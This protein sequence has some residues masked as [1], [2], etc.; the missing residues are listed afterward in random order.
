MLIIFITFTLSLEH[1]AKLIA[2]AAAQEGLRRV[3]I[4][5]SSQGNVALSRRISDAFEKEWL[6]L[7][8]SVGM[9]LTASGE[10][11]DATKLKTSFDKAIEAM[12]KSADKLDKT[13]DKAADKATD[14]SYDK[15]SAAIEFVFIA[16]DMNAARGI[17]PYLPQGL[18]VYATSHSLDPRAGALENLDLDSVRYLEMPWFAERDHIAV[19]SYPRPPEATSADYERL[20][21]LGIDAWRI[22]MALLQQ[23]VS[24]ETTN[25]VALTVM[26]T[27]V[28]RAEKASAS[29]HAPRP[30]KPIDGVS[31]RITLDG[32]QFTRGLSLLELRDGRPQLIKSAE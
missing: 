31:G 32:S 21:A 10:L 29:A 23:D 27:A 15:T 20:Y 12:N 4:V 8:G 14:K 2:R 19:V 24:V 28:L 3:A 13:A 30:F 5:N 1:D 25:S 16:A 7:G 22:M 9:K 6:R 11:Q 17:R 18:P 26:P